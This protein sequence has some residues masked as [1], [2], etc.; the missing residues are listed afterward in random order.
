[1]LRPVI[2]ICCDLGEG[3]GSYQM[4]NDDQIIELITSANIACGFH[5]GDPRTINNAIKSA[6]RFGTGI[7]AHPSF[8]DLI[9]FGRRN[10]ELSYEEVYTDVLYQLGAIYAFTKAN[11]ANLQHVLPHGQLANMANVNSTYSEAIADA[12]YHFDPK[13]IVLSQPGYLL[14]ASKERGLKTALTIFAD[15]AY[16]ADGKL[17][18]RKELGSVI[19]DRDIIIKRTLKMVLEKKVTTI[20]GEELDIHGDTL[21]V[22]GDT[23]GSLQLVKEIKHALLEH[24]VEVLPLGKW[25]K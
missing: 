21:L 23:E 2:D 6:I 4:T 13:L 22:H 24:G 5:A 1:M 25:I 18:P 15:R 7:G 16:K 12:I 11:D 19:T 17:V 10:M 14:D 3:F 9:G 20:T 8:P